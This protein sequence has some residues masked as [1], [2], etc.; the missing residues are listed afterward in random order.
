MLQMANRQRKSTMQL[1]STH[2]PDSCPTESIRVPILYVTGFLY[3]ASRLVLLA[4]SFSSIRKMLGSV[5]F[6]RDLI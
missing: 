5:Y 2:G 3:C 4:I 6:A 1:G